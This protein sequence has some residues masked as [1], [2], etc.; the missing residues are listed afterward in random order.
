ML[1]DTIEK[2]GYLEKSLGDTARYKFAI[3]GK[4]AHIIYLGIKV[5]KLSTREDI[6]LHI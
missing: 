3:A 5:Q 4:A 1:H 6:F 2:W